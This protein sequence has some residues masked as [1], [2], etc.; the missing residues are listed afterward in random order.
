[1]AGE[2]VLMGR[3]QKMV[4]QNCTYSMTAV[5]KRQIRVIIMFFVE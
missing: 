5:K 3:D 1:M 2:E 4:A